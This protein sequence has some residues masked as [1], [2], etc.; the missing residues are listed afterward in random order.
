[1]V[2]ARGCS[3]AI[4]RWIC[5]RSPLRSP[6]TLPLLPFPRLHPSITNPPARGRRFLRPSHSRF[7]T[8]VLVTPRETPGRLRTSQ[9]NVAETPSLFF[10]EAFGSAFRLTLLT[11]ASRGGEPRRKA[12][13]VRRVL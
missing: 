5:L 9:D 3:D 10:N 8:S 11:F 6:L 13:Q 12:T 1:M 7:L 4:S 2:L